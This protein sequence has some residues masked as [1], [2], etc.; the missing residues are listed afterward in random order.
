MKRHHRCC[1]SY[2]V[3]VIFGHVSSLT[4]RRGRQFQAG[5]STG[6][7][8]SYCPRVVFSLR[9]YCFASYPEQARGGDRVGGR[10]VGGGGAV[11]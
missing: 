1:A 2:L 3:T 4:L 11:F 9:L 5:R 8:T 6:Y 10:G 7:S